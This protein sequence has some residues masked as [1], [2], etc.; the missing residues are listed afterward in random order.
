MLPRPDRFY[1]QT[2]PIEIALVSALDVHRHGV[3][4]TLG[5]LSLSEATWLLKSKEGDN[6]ALRSFLATLPFWREWPLSRLDDRALREAVIRQVEAGSL[7]AIRRSQQQPPAGSPATE[8]GPEVA[9]VRQ[10]EAMLHRE[11]RP[12]FFRGR[13]Y[14]LLPA[15]QFYDGPASDDLE[16]VRGN[17][18]ATVLAGLATEPQHPAPVRDLLKRVTPFVSLGAQG[19]ERPKGL[20]LLRR[21]TVRRDQVTSDEPALT[22]AA[23]RRLRDEQRAPIELER[24]YHDDEPLQGAP[25]ELELS[26]GTI[27]TGKLNAQGRAVIPDLPVGQA[28]VTYG[29]DARPYERKDKRMNPHYQPEFGDPQ[30]E[31]LLGRY[32]KS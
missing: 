23:L 19:A 32:V 31:A 13:R 14:Q 5:Q 17:E 29:P 21:V 20:V 1:L 25:F 22:P 9:L 18:A 27:I 30:I 15:R 4:P 10:L 26:D 2:F 28:S 8:P 16:R 7:I 6:R 3:G 12:L 11:R 24:R